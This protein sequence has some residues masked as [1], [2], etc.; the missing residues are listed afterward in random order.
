MTS[1]RIPT[2]HTYSTINYR[3]NKHVPTS[4]CQI[5]SYSWFCE[6]SCA[7]SSGKWVVQGVDKKMGGAFNIQKCGKCWKKD[8]CFVHD[9]KKIYGWYAHGNN[10]CFQTVSPHKQENGCFDQTTLHRKILRENK[11]IDSRN[12]LSIERGFP[13]SGSFHC[14]NMNWVAKP[15]SRWSR[16]PR[17]SLDAGIPIDDVNVSLE[18][19]STS[20]RITLVH[21][22]LQIACCNL[23][24]R[25]LKRICWRKKSFF[26]C[27]AF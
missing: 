6:N 11:K 14:W 5:V 16:K 15:M 1:I 10:M 7:Y 25:S 17:Q 8:V 26:T 20:L 23:M 22:A 3:S 27:M 21:S 24:L 18:G 9:K 12:Y 19:M 4:V 13:N 2:K